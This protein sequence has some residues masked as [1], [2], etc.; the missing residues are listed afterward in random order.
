MPRPQSFALE[1]AKEITVAALQGGDHTV[2]GDTGEDVA[3]FY[4]SVYRKI[5]KLSSETDD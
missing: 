1:A 4:E 5:L 3:L 2:V